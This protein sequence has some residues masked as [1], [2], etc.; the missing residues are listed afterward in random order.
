MATRWLLPAPKQKGIRGKAATF[1]MP[2]AFLAALAV[3]AL[4]E[5]TDLR[6][7]LERAGQRNPRVQV[8][9]DYILLTLSLRDSQ[10]RQHLME[11]SGGPELLN[12]YKQA[13]RKR[14]DS[15]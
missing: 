1:R 11:Q 3:Y 12:R 10:L 2:D 6:G 15:A 8:S 5:T 7:R 14:P 13:Q 4:A 9:R